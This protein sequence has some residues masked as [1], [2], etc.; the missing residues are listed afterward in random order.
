MHDRLIIE[1]FGVLHGAAEG[2]LAIGAL[3]LIALTLTTQL[4]WW[5]RGG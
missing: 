3:V 1:L 2:S 4:W 5:R